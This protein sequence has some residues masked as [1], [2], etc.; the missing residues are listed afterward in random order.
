MKPQKTISNP[1][2]LQKTSKAKHDLEGGDLVSEKISRGALES[3]KKANLAKIQLAAS[4][5]RAKDKEKN[6]V[7]ASQTNTTLKPRGRRFR[8]TDLVPKRKPSHNNG[9]DDGK[10]VKKKKISMFELLDWMNE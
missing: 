7:S 3:S 5:G 1:A 2:Q 4:K 6:A 10:P 9:K 8:L